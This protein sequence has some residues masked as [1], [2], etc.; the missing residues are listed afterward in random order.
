MQ[1]SDG[2]NAGFTDG[3]PWFALNPN[4]TVINAENALEDKNSVFYYYQKLILLRKEYQVFLDG[5][6]T[7]LLPEDEKIFAYVRKNEDSELLVAFQGE[8]YILTDSRYTEQVELEA[9]EFTCVDIGREG[10]SKTIAAM[11]QKAFAKEGRSTLRIGFENKEISYMQYQ[12]FVDTFA[13]ELTGMQVEFVPLEDAVNVY[14]EVKTEDEIAKLA[15]AEQIGDEAFTEIVKFIHENWKDGLT[16]QRVALQLE[17]EMRLR[18][19]EGTSFD[20]IAASGS[21]SSLPHAMPQPK[22]LT[23]GDFL[24]MDFGCMYQGYCS[25]M[26]R[27]IHIGEV[28]ES[29]QKK[30]YDTVLQAQLA[31]LSVVKPGMVCSDVDKCARDIIAD[32]G[33]GDYF[34]HG[35]GHSVGLFIHEEPRFSMKCDAVL[36]PGV[37]ITVEPGI[38]LPGRFGVRIEDM[39]VVTE[40][41]YQNLASSPKEL[42]C[43]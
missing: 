13:K 36:K 28:V 42:I 34:G 38:Y 10:Y 6:F 18:G 26:T 12:A 20:T 17:Y 31:A 3:T 30:V 7:L 27:T 43:V 33:Y 22:L 19:A 25:D 5:S 15:R 4:Y 21:N 16:E 2:K 29:E 41:G 8:Q 37:V 32:A 1:W 11:V 39:I 35:L 23:E 40:D 14:R 24:T 9:P